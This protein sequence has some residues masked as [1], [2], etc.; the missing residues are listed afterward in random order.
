MSAVGHAFLAFLNYL[1]RLARL[2]GDVF[3]SLWRFRLRWR[4]I[5]SQIVVIGFGS[6][7]VALV[8]G[9]FTGAVFTAQMYYQFSK[10]GV[11][12]VVG[13]IVAIAMC[14]ELA[15]VLV[16][17]MVTGRVGAAMA[18]EIGTMKVNEQIDALRCLAVHPVDYLV[19]PRVIGIMISM[20]LL[21]AESIVLGIAASYFVAV[22]LY[23]VPDAWFWTHLNNWM[24]LEDLAFGMIKGFFFGALIVLVACEKGLTTENGAV[25]VG[26]STTQAVVIASLCILVSNFFLTLFLTT[27]FPY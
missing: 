18:A 15:P 25:G 27:I 10:M 24:E 7:L 17:I 12:T 8:T 22:V 11:E 13:G 19:V 5:C 23:G 4:T 1:G 26:R 20:P 16:G 2:F 9:A 3:G 6:Q 14:R 21:I